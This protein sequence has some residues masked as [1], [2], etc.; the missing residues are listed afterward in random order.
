MTLTRPDGTKI[1]VPDDAQVEALV[2][3]L[4]KTPSHRP[5]E[6]VQLTSFPEEQS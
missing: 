3:R 4:K 2:P 1:E 5:P 6:W